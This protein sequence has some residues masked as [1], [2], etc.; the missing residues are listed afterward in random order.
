M[1][2][3]RKTFSFIVVF[4]VFYTTCNALT[5]ST[6]L[7]NADQQRL[8]KVLSTAFPLTEL[9]TAHYAALGYSLLNEKLPEINKAYLLL[10]KSIFIGIRNYAAKK[11]RDPCK[12]F[13]SKIDKKRLD[14]VFHASSGSKLVPSCKLTTTGL[15]QT[16]DAAISE[17]TSM[18]DIYYA[19]MSLHN[20]NL[21][22]DNNKVSRIM[23]AILKKD[24]SVIKYV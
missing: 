8:K 10:P 16:L 20:L 13:D 24:D 5:P 3:I 21:K 7:T 22:I 2:W 12:F 18:Q 6:F 23:T 1:D 19:V 15:Q 14:T 17:D 9:T 4:T 11:K